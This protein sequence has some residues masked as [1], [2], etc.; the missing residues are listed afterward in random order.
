MKSVWILNHYAQEPGGPGGTRHYSLAR[1]L[2]QHD[3]SATV[4][5]ASTEHGTGRE[6]LMPGES[7]RLD[8]LDGVPFLWVRTS[9]YSGNG[10]DRVRNML[11]YTRSV[12]KAEH[13]RQLERPDAIVG[14]SVHPFAAWA[15]LRLA[16]RYGVPFVFEVRDLWP[17]TLVDLGRLSE[18]H[19][20]TLGLRVLEHH[21]YKHA[22]QIVVLLPRASEYIEP[23]GIAA[24]KIVW[25]PN[26]IELDIFPSPQP[27]QAADA[28]TV[29][30]F[31]AH[32][33][34]NGLDNV[35][36][37]IGL[38]QASNAE[39]LINLRIIGDGPLKPSLIQMAR[40]MDLR[41]VSF[42]NPVPKKQ[43]AAVAADADAFIFNLIDAPVF[44][45]GISSN[46]LF[47]FMACARPVIFACNADNNPVQTA[48]GGVTVPAGNPQA[49]ARAMMDLSRLS[50]TQQQKMGLAN[51]KHVEENY[52][53]DRLGAK[54]AGALE[55]A[56]RG[57]V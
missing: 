40:Q 35:L 55:A 1:S 38:V 33:T 42:E 32:G 12:L 5:A 24:E 52:G 56:L 9:S 45:Y 30:Y 46:K 37:A 27:K 20:V 4:I 53:F 13:T 17:Q 3:W 34:A 8:T 49:L 18:R 22:A 26:G 43:I 31:G 2:A 7:R 21:L 36:R 16:R 48:G 39:R 50:Q 51:R 14:S 44:K 6:R 19:P 47:D 41:N 11:S 23:L 29:M 25:V 10:A 54:F 28:F 57:K 15:G